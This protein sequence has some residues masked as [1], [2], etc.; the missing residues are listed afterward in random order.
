MMKVFRNTLIATMVTVVIVMMTIQ[1]ANA[2]EK[3]EVQLLAPGWG[4]LKFPPPQAGAYQLPPLGKAAD[5]NIVLSDR[6]KA[7]LR[8]ILIGNKLT[9]LSFIYAS[10]DD[11]NGCPLST[12]VMHAVKQRLQSHADI[13]SKLR[14][15]SISFD[16]ENDTPEVMKTYGRDFQSDSFEWLFGTFDV[17]YPRSA[18]QKTLKSYGQSVLRQFENTQEGLTSRVS[19]HMLK[20]YLIDQHQRIRNIYGVDFLHPDILIADIQTLLME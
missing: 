20:V 15:L 4:N 12:F 14:L 11:M 1:T 19:S 6:S 2:A 9:V 10:C 16:P 5:A 17:S 3:I 13:T 7:R 18:M 8:E